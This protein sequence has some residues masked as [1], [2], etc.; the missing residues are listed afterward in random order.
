RPPWIRRNRP[1]AA[2]AGALTPSAAADEVDARSLPPTV[3]TKT[4]RLNIARRFGSAMILPSARFLARRLGW[5]FSVFIAVR[6]RRRVLPVIRP[7]EFGTWETVAVDVPACRATSRI[8]T[9]I[10]SS[11]LRAAS[12]NRLPRR[13]RP[14]RGPVFLVSLTQKT[15]PRK[16]SPLDLAQ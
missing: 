16:S 10:L 12:D 3:G 4:R 8:V 7:V 1:L 15:E 9:V 5:Y 2:L 13:F 6:T 14:R 11:A